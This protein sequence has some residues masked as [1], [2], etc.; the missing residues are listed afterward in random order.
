MGSSQPVMYIHVDTLRRIFFQFA[1]TVFREENL[2]N[3]GNLGSFIRD[4]GLS[5]AKPGWHTD[6]IIATH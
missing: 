4:L 5:H 6:Y 2:G 3:L 1:S